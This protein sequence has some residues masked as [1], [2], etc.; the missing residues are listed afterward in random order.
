MIDQGLFDYFITRHYPR[1]EVF[2][3]LP[4][5]VSIE[6]F[7]PELLRLRKARAVQIPMI[8]LNRQPLWFVMTD[9]LMASGDRISSMARRDIDRIDPCEDIMTEGLMDEAFFTSFVEG[10]PVSR[11]ECRRFLKSGEDPSGVG[12]LL[13]QNNLSAIRYMAEHRYEPYSISMLHTCVRLLTSAMDVESD[14]YRTS[15]NHLVPG[16]GESNTEVPSA[17][18]IPRMIESLCIFLNECEMHPLLKAAIAHAYILL[19]RPYDEGN[20]RLARLVSCSFLLGNGYSFFRQFALSGLIAQDGVLYY[21]AMGTVQDDRNGGDLTCFCEYYLGMLSRGVNGFDAYLAQKRASEE[22]KRRNACQTAS[23]GVPENPSSPPNENKEMNP[24]LVKFANV[25]ARIV[26]PEAP[27]SGLKKKHL[28]RLNKIETEGSLAECESPEALI[29]MIIKHHST[30]SAV[31]D[32]KPLN[33][34][35]VMTNEIILST[36]SKIDTSTSNRVLL[37]YRL[38]EENQGKKY[39]IAEMAKAQQVSKETSRRACYILITL[40]LIQF[41]QGAFSKNNRPVNCFY[42]NG[43]KAA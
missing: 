36:L 34:K 20:E 3:R 16:R 27:V 10:A 17:A 29:L 1:A 22:D 23:S 42:H 2:N 38:L 6:E 7:W 9:S 11:L 35:F 13:A 12:E 21:K 40:G 24:G 43:S 19:V 37:L 28:S 18:E 5:S 33:G 32:I 4:F 39:T 25:P 30:G 15:N 26:S 31:F 8:G 41:A 14:G